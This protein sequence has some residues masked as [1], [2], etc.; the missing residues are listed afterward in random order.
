VQVRLL[1]DSDWGQCKNS[2]R[3]V[4]GNLVTIGSS[5]VSWQ[6]KRQHALALSKCEAEYMAMGD[7]AKK[8]TYVVSFLTQFVKVLRPSP[9]FYDNR[10][11]GYLASDEINN[12]RS[13]H[14]D[15]RF[16]FIRSWVKAGIFVLV[17]VAS[18][19]N[20]SDIFT[21]QPELPDFNRLRLAIMSAPPAPLL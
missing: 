21:K 2:R 11:A 5:P 8:E 19:D 15:I 18:A 14:I 20:L 6:S 7:G 4:S 13:K 16:H 12:H 17:P 1:T 10:G 3:S 9:L